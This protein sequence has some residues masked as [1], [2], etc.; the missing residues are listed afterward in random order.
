MDNFNHTEEQPFFNSIE[1]NEI[2]W[3]AEN[4]IAMKLQA[5]IKKVYQANLG[6]KISPYQM[7]DYLMGKLSK[8]ININSV[9]RSITNLKN[10]GSLTMLKPPNHLLRIGKEGRPEHYYMLTTGEVPAGSTTVAHTY[11]KGQKTASQTAVEIINRVAPIII[12]EN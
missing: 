2:E 7:Q 5:L 12:F 6:I 8:K 4:I 3:Q 1:L 10:E 11:K 9:R